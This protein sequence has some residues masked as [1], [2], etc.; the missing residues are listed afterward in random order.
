MHRYSAGSAEGS[1]ALIM[2]AALAGCGGDDDELVVSAAS[3]LED[4]L[5]RAG[6]CAVLLRRLGRAR[7]ADPPGGATS[8]S[9]PPRT[10][11][12][13]TSCSR[14]ASSRSRSC[15][16]RNRLV[17]AVPARG[18]EGGLAR[19]PRARPG[20]RSPR[21]ARTCR[22]A[23]TPARCSTGSARSAA[24]RSWP[25][26][27]RR[28]PTSAA[29][30][31]S[32]RQGA[33]DAGFVYVTD[34]GGDRRR[35][36]GDRAAPPSCSPDVEYGVAVVEGCRA[37]EEARRTSS[38]ACASGAGRDALEAA[39]FTRPVTRVPGRDGR[40]ADP[41]ARVPR[42]PARRGLRQHQPGQ[43]RREPRRPV[44]AR[45][46]AAEPAVHADR[47]GDHPGSSARRPPT[48]SRRAPSAG[49]PRS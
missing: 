10:R 4:G 45:R 7:G 21:V 40:G 35:A 19:R 37:P 22:S 23:P 38:T 15:S 49:A 25:T 12:C 44:V 42:R 47:A 14:R 39:G 3:S 32:S 11:A 1:A 28:S 26:S 6:R 5:H 48:C 30:S 36:G 46:P 9:S 2:T 33:V 18:R 13:R 27:A 41:H 17:L 24:S 16:P 43:P 29:S 31:A 34:V 8:T 20:S